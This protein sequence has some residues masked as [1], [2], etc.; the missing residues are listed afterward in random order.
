MPLRHG[1]GRSSLASRRSSLAP[2]D[3][4]LLDVTQSQPPLLGV[5]KQEESRSSSE[6]H[7][8]ESQKHPTFVL[9]GDSKENEAENEKEEGSDKM[10]EG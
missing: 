9:G 3:S 5:N 10:D 6:R 2:A 8:S 4:S 7:S 1:S